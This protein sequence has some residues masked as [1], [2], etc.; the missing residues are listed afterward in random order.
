MKTKIITNVSELLLM[1]RTVELSLDHVHKGGIPFSALVV[2]KQGKVL[3]QGVNRVK[4]LNDPTAHAEILAIR[5][6]CKLTNGV[7]LSEAILYASG[8]PC[9]L[10]YLAAKWAGINRIYIASDRHEVA[11]LGFDYRWTYDFFNTDQPSNS[12]SVEKLQD[13]GSSFPFGRWAELTY[14]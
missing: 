11:K 3:G 6:A 4:E 1:K 13:V 5:D 8:E 7:D 2:D 10:C 12:I 9:G 14:R